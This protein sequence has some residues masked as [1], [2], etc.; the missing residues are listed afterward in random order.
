MERY[1]SPDSL[2]IV[3]VPQPVPK[4]NEVLV[5]VK[6]ASVN[7]ADWHLIHGKPLPVRIM[8]GLIKP[9]YKTLGA[10]VSG[11]VHQAGNKVKTFKK[12]D[13]VFGDLSGC[14]FGGFAEYVIAPAKFLAVKPTNLNYEEAASL[15]MASIT[16]LQGLRD[17]GKIKAGHHVLING[18]SGGV[19]S[20]AIQLAKYYGAS[21][22]AVCS[23]GKIGNA[24]Q[25]GADNVIDYT[26][27]DFTKGEVKYDLI[28]D[29]VSNHALR[30]IRK[31]LM[32]QGHY[33]AVAF[34]LETLITGAIR[35]AN[36]GQKM[37]NLLAS[38]NQTDLQFI[39]KLAENGNIFPV[40]NKIFRFN[41]LPKALWE[42]GIASPVGKLVV[43]MTQ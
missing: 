42:I 38:S 32:P 15:P 29:I 34:S 10:D 4:E 5:N 14:G 1:G 25:N 8:A 28:L 20:F 17:I 26:Q 43:S 11:V 30:E 16:A 12:G 31:V 7:K 39:S 13:D 40:D 19:G 2:R 6:A 37:K 27:E 22:T 33:V 18:A 3:E 36:S 35:S 24:R 9:K 23:T 41:D 21:V